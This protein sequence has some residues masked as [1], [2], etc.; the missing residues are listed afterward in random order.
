MALGVKPLSASAGNARP[1]Q[2]EMVFTHLDYS[3]SS[4]FFIFGHTM[5]D[6]ELP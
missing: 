6:A 2:A 5:Q 1:G 3:P 4:H